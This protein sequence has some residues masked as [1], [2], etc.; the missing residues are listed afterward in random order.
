[1]AAEGSARAKMARRVTKHLDSYLS[2]VQLGV[3]FA[4]LALG[5]VGEPAFASIILPR[6]ARLG[7]FAP[8]VAHSIAAGIAFTLISALHI[9]F[10]ELGPKYLAIDK[11]VDVALVVAHPLRAFYVVM[12]P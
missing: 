9:I 2:A 4:S 5:W 12:Y 3:T 6:L 10:G 11:T 8:S 7:V 1:M